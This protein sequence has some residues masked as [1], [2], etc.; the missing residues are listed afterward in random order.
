M[1]LSRDTSPSIST[2]QVILEMAQAL[3]D[4]SKNPTALQQASE[5]AHALPEAEKRKAEAARLDMQNYQDLVA[6]NAAQIAFLTESAAALAAEKDSL[7]NMAA[8]LK[9]REAKLADNSGVLNDSLDNLAK[10]KTEH[11]RRE[12]MVA[13]KETIIAAKE[14]SLDDRGIA[15]DAFEATLKDRAAKLKTLTD[16]F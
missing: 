4:L 2:Y 16:G 3:A 15:L 1:G 10:L 5:A 12:A 7:L 6:K 9:N 11:D 14:N 8:D 13:K